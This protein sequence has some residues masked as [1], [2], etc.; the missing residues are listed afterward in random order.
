MKKNI[1]I[2]GSNSSGSN[3][4]NYLLDKIFFV[5]GISGKRE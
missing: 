4:I 5:I 2:I 3:F 1:L